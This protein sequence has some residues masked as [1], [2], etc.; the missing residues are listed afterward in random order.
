M[1]KNLLIL[2]IG[3]AL[4]S[5]FAPAIAQLADY[6]YK[7]EAPKKKVSRLPDM[8]HRWK[9]GDIMLVINGPKKFE[10][11]V[12]VGSAAYSSCYVRIWEK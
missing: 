10:K 1:K 8:E 9:S 11:R 3:L 6:K 12:P 7:I 4:G 5:L 2:S